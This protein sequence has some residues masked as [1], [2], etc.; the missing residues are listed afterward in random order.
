LEDLR[1]FR[2]VRR[3]NFDP[4]DAVLPALDAVGD[5]EL[6]ETLSRDVCRALS[7]DEVN[8]CLRRFDA[9]VRFVE[10]IDSVAKT[11]REVFHFV[12]RQMVVVRDRELRS[13]DVL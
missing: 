1:D 6:V 7:I 12:A 11:S 8:E 3:W 10:R 13:D 4:I 2:F 9:D 5:V